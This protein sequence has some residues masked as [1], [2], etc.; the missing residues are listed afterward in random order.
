MTRKFLTDAYGNEGG[1]ASAEFY[2]DWAKSYED[3]V[4]ENGYAT[5]GRC[6][7]ALASVVGDLGAAVI[8]I[9]CGT[10]LSGAA[11]RDAGFTNINGWDPSAEMLEQAHASGIYRKLE[12]IDPEAP[13]SAH[14]GVYVNAMAAG[15]F[16]PAVAPPEAFDQTFEFL[17]RGGCLAVSLN[18]HAIEDGAH[19]WRMNAILDAGIAVMKF[20]E[21]GDHMPGIDMKSWVY[22]LE[23]T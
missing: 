13:L 18:D 12:Q 6:A 23:K 7:E 8:D 2:D 1:T 22:V 21:Y 3:E 20:K 17:P 4:K 15:V 19:L 10:G 9:G 5:P 14:E 16:S 11:L